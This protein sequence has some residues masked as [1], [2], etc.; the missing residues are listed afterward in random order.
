MTTSQRTFREYTL[1]AEKSGLF[2]ETKASGSQGVKG[3][4]GDETDVHP[5][6][7][8]GF[9]PNKCVGIGSGASGA[10]RSAGAGAGSM[11]WG[12][13]GFKMST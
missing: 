12:P 6:C 3:Q 8:P 5:N 13:P 2:R 10:K 11:R 7:L 4:E 9:G 1:R